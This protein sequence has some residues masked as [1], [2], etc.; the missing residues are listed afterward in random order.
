MASTG[1][2]ST[3]TCWPE[4]GED[5]LSLALQDVASR[6]RAYGERHSHRNG[7]VLGDATE[8]EVEFGEDDLSLALQYFASG[9]RTYGA[10]HS[11][12]NGGILGD[13][14]GDEVGG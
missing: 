3:S 2:H 5:D 14:T 11:H 6:K 7:G 12:R 1:S 4:F 8:D 13:V 10:R 9:K